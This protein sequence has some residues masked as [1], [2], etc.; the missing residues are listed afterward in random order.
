MNRFFFRRPRL[1]AG[2]LFFASV[3]CTGAAA[4]RAQV[5]ARP[6]ASTSGALLATLEASPQVL[7]GRAASTVT[8]RLAPGVVPP[9]DARIG[10]FLAGTNARLAESKRAFTVVNGA[11]QVSLSLDADPGR[12]EFRLLRDDK[13]RTPLTQSARVTVSGID[14]EPGW[15]LFNG[16]PVVSA[17][18]PQAAQA[19]RAPLFWPGL[20]RSLRKSDKARTANARTDAPVAWRTLALP[21]LQAWLSN[22]AQARADALR[23]AQEVRAGGPGGLVGC[24]V[25]AEPSG[26]RGPLPA[27]EA[28]VA[29]VQAAR[30]ACEAI[31]PDAALILRVAGSTGSSSALAARVVDLAAPECDAV[32]VDN[33][34]AREAAAL[35]PLKVARRVAEEQPQF[36]LPIFVGATNAASVLEAWMGGATGVVLADA[37][38]T[39]AF[40]GGEDAAEL[41]QILESNLGLFVGSVTLE[42]TGLLR[43]GDV[44][45]LFR[46]AREVG[47]VPLLAR[48][49]DVAGRRDRS[50]REGRR[51]A[52][53]FAL[54]WDA[55]TLGAPPADLLQ[56]LR[57]AAGD[58]SRA[59]LEGNPFLF[60][61][62]AGAS[63]AQSWRDLL[64][65]SARPIESASTSS[66]SAAPDASSADYAAED[67]AASTSGRASV[68]KMDDVWTFGLARGGELPVRQSSVVTPT[69][70]PSPSE[71]GD[72]EAPREE[73]ERERERRRPAPRVVA[74]L[75]D[76]STALLISPA[77]ASLRRDA[78]GALL[79]RGDIV[80]APHPPAATSA[81]ASPALA[82]YDA[83]ISTLLQPA[84]VRLFER[85]AAPSSA[86]GAAGSPAATPTSEL[87]AATGVR[88]SVRA[89]ARGTLLV[90]LV[91]PSQSTRTLRMQT[92][93]PG[94]YVVDLA[95]NRLLA[96][97]TRGLR[98]EVDLDV[99]PNGFRLLAL[100]AD[101]K[102]FDQDRNAERLKAR[103]R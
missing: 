79:P 89:S 25:D 76:G 70:T 66:T 56:A 59:Y 9:K 22:A 75:Q 27:P 84:L 71:L 31:A 51:Y 40:S 6:A 16:S 54:R 69:R 55:A 39:S 58:G 68:L 21:P 102:S 19:A 4:V 15:W 46:R 74:T 63:D 96:A 2:A 93:A 12:Y 47:R 42:D 35:W 100:A 61:G 26:V 8:L 73:T 103:L 10:L 3:L 65:A 1:V 48:T 36:D 52:E 64:Q 33:F 17:G 101:A 77:T 13:A 62:T 57:D 45:S 92:Q 41:V 18:A 7:A 32:F 20:K 99:P 34:D 94:G 14:R 60:S 82:A 50:G 86:A 49:L 97:R 91:N 98:V 53:P 37:A 83:A 38:S 80:W 5:P 78:Q 30:S 85:G 95:L 29:A 28:I 81:S 87:A 88:V 43:A 11:M 72:A 23:A 67:E 90:A 44:L 24:V